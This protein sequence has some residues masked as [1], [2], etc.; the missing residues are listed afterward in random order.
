MLFLCAVGRVLPHRPGNPASQPCFVNTVCDAAMDARYGAVP[1]SH[2]K[3]NESTDYT[4]R[5]CH[6]ERPN[7]S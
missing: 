6:A 1:T 5:E 3:Q 4:V 2:P 7:W